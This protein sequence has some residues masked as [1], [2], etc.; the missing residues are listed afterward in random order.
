MKHLSIGI[1]ADGRPFR[2]PLDIVTMTQAILARKRSGKS[3]TAQKIAEELLLAGQQ[4]V[5]IDP[6]SAWWGLRSSADGSGPG[7][8][9][10]V[11][12]GEHGD[13]AL[14]YRAGATLARAVVEHHFSAIFDVGNMVYEEQCKFTASFANELLRLNREAM[15][16]F[17][18]EA[19]VFAPEKAFGKEEKMSLHA[20]SRMVKQGGIKGIGCTMITQRPQVLNKNILSQVDLLTVLRMSGPLEIDIMVKWIRSEVSVEFADQVRAALPSLPVG[21]AFVCSAPQEIGERVVIGQKQTF[22]SGATPKPGERKAEPKVL[23]PIDIQ[24]LG[25]QVAKAVQEQ[26]EQDPAELRKTVADLR[27]QLAA[28]PATVTAHPEETAALRAAIERR[29]LKITA[30]YSEIARLSGFANEIRTITESVIS[31]LTPR[32]FDIEALEERAFEEQLGS[33]MPTERR[34]LSV[35]KAL[36]VQSAPVKPQATASTNSAGPVQLRPVARQILEA[37]AQWYPNARTQAQ[38]AAL[39]GNKPRGGSW[40]SYVSE[41]N[42]AGFILKD[43]KMM[44]C[45]QAGLDF[46][47]EDR[48]PAPAT[49][50]DV[51]ALW[52]PKLR[53]QARAILDR[54]WEAGKPLSQEEVAYSMGVAPRGG[55]WTSYLSELKTARLVLKYGDMLELD[56]ETFLL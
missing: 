13:A 21:T 44:Q 38:V 28:K 1:T 35:T 52:R 26:K 20:V 40:T 42:R 14:D 25:E 29:N 7:F 22:N 23:A 18:D 12:G 8:P 54:L 4:I 45:T 39:I 5:A 51:L 15:H 16:V 47:G 53:P 49:P 56:P 2:L 19:D 6:T 50:D 48:V 27:R 32:R 11:F 17:I 9:V 36:P 37:L 30:L 41:L 55:S 34:S 33:S 46:L 31:K 24:R 43:G 3:Y 10:V